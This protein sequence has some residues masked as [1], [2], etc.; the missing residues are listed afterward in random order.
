MVEDFWD[1]FRRCRG[2]ADCIFNELVKETAAKVFKKDLFINL[3]NRMICPNCGS[4]LKL[5]LATRKL[6]VFKCDRC[7]K[8]YVVRIK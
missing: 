5:V 4:R 3:V 8:E 6:K 1:L 7:K 2:D